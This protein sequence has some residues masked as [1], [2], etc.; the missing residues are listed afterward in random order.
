M[1]ELPEVETVR[2][3][4][5]AAV[6]GKHI[7]SV[8]LYRADVVRGSDTL[9][10]GERIDRVERKGKQLALISEGGRQ[11]GAA[12]R[13][14]CVHLGMSGSLR[15]VHRSD[16]D[17]TS[18][19][20][21][22]VVWELP[23]GMQVLFR[24][25]RRF[26]G[27]WGFADEAELLETRWKKLGPDALLITPKQLHTGL[28]RTKRALKAALLDQHLVAGLGNIYVDE[29]LYATKLHPLKPASEV[30]R[31]ESQRLVRTTRRILSRAIKAGGSTLRDYVDAQ[32]Q[33][34]GF[35]TQHKV[36]SRG[37][38]PCPS[39]GKPL[40]TMVV[41]GRTTTACDRCQLGAILSGER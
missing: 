6:R 25:P 21:V 20:H 14:V 33:S 13:C 17:A 2:R 7:A 4:L 40:D 15:V 30:A 1:P 34:G 29:L 38:E 26:G 8:R 31:P 35:Q 22:H 11:S 36:Y 3:T 5:E 23:D 9:L 18:D 37:G 27:V 41:A 12:C 19:K 39:C 10:A 32:G 24:D 28:S 16:S